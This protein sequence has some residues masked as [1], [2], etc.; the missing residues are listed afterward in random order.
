MTKT[1]LKNSDITVIC[2]VNQMASEYTIQKQFNIPSIIPIIIGLKRRSFCC[3]AIPFPIFRTP[4]NPKMGFT[5]ISPLGRKCRGVSLIRPLG[6]SE[7]YISKQTLLSGKTIKH[8]AR[9][10]Q[11]L[12]EKP[13]YFQQ[14]LPAQ[15][16]ELVRSP[17]RHPCQ[18]S[19][20]CA[21]LPALHHLSSRMAW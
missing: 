20:S 5:A 14:A 4:P 6:G 1:E 12:Q 2:T 7:T 15:E 11:Q 10:H 8:N 13:V 16:H 19:Q 17:D 18:Q 3:V 21:S 9:I